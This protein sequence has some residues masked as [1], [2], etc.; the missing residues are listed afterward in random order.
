MPG[1]GECVESVAW[2]DSLCEQNSL[3]SSQQWECRR[4][5]CPAISRQDAT[6]DHLLSHLYHLGS[7]AY[8]YILG[9]HRACPIT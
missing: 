4:H 7:G 6:A 3:R 8:I 1:R 2:L 9:S 5:T